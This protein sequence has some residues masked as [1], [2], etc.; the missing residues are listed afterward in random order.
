MNGLTSHYHAVV[1]DMDGVLIERLA[2]RGVPAVSGVAEFVERLAPAGVPCAVATS[3][4]RHDV[5][6]LLGAIGVARRFRAIVTSADVRFGKP[7]PEVYVLAARELATPP[8][9]CLAFEDSVVGVHAACA[10]GMAVVGVTTAYT[11][12]ELR[13]AGAGRT[14]ESFEGF[15]WPL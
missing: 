7:D 11:G 5:D 8:R 12:A 10:A 14:I 9:R 15:D 13:A 3:A 1:F 6:R 4:S 2:R